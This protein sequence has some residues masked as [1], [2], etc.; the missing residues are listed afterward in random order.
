MEKRAEPKFS[1]MNKSEIITL[2]VTA[3]LTFDSS[4]SQSQNNTKIDSLMIILSHT[5]GIERAKLFYE[6]PENG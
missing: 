5:S 4:I 3:L 1:R 2:L 6:F